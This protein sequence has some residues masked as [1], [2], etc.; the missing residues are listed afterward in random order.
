M[1]G[2]FPESINKAIIESM[3]IHSEMASKILS[4]ELIAKGFAGLMFDVL[5]RGMGGDRV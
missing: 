4:N 1:L 3:D 5:M 2:Q